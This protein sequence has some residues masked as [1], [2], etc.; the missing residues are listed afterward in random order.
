M[1]PSSLIFLTLLGCCGVCRAE[2]IRLSNDWKVKGLPATAFQISGK[3]VEM[4]PESCGAAQAVQIIKGPF[5]SGELLRFSADVETTGVTDEKGNKALRPYDLNLSPRN[6]CL[7][8]A[9][10]D[11]QGRTLSVCGSARLLGS[12]N[13]RLELETSVQ[14]NVE[15]VELRLMA[16]LVTGKVRC[17]NMA[18]EK[19]PA[20]PLQN[21][22]E[23][24]ILTNR[25]GRCFWQIDGKT[26][27]LVMYFGNNQF[28][29]D[30]R[31]LEEMEKA[32]GAGVP[33]LSFNLYLPAMASDTE[34]LKIIERF[35]KP[36]PDA[37]F[38]PRVWL[39]PGEAYQNSFPEEMMKYAGGRIGGY[40]S[41]S[42]EHWKKFTDHNLRELVKL[43]RRSPYAKQFAG[44]KLTYHQTGEWIYW[45]PQSSAGYD[46]PTRRDFARWLENKYG[47]KYENITVPTEE[48]RNTGT[49]GEF[50]DPKT[51]QREIDFSLFYNTANAD[52][53][54]RFARTVKEA[55]ENKSLV[56]AF[57]GYLFELAWNENWPQQAGHLG[58][59]KLCRSPYIDIIGAPYSYNPIGRGFGLPVDLHGP[60]DG[61]NRYGKVA[62]IEEDT[63]TH[64]ALNPKAG[65]GWDPA[66]APGYA[67]RTADMT[68][69]VAV[70]RRDLGV[71]AA[72]NQMLLWQNLF[73]EGRFNDRQIWDMYKPY[74]AWM[75]QSAETAPPFQPQV[76]VLADPENITLLKNK[77]YG[78]T[79]RWLYQNR[80]PL[81]RVDASIGYYLQSDLDKLPGSVRCI[82]MLN[83]FRITAEQKTVLKER[84]MRDGKM[85]IFC[86]MPD[87]YDD[88]GVTPDGTGFC[89]INLELKPGPIIPESRANG[90][91]SPDSRGAHFG[92]KQFG[93]QKEQPCAPFLKVTDSDAVVFANYTATGEAS[94]AL[95][96][97]NGWTSVYLGSP[98][99]PP[100]LWRELFRKAD[101]HLYLDDKTFSQ[102]F[103]KPDFIQAD[104]KFL[105]IQS[106]CGGTK[107]IHLP[108]RAAKV[109]R[110]DD[111][112]PQLIAE[113]CDEFRADLKPGIPAFFLCE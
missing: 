63:F 86:Y 113:D 9:Q 109:Y 90:K 104:G 27:P 75:Q 25:L 96:E 10:I 72:R 14:E 35:M 15:T 57:Y 21:I 62:M 78:I 36:F 76:A 8:L 91:I 4:R 38:M 66:I 41:A 28:N 59:E 88:S 6:V 100:G 102:D 17:R 53:I 73:S 82:V 98:G 50:R 49:L 68:Q 112:A 11:A 106:A 69:T 24:K 81:N 30:D 12:E 89:G 111:S 22:P 70:L 108:A 37:Y 105:M 1:N 44:L 56:A 33:V 61:I 65:D 67:S 23:A 80:F 71:A 45:E 5:K 74:L 18:F 29:R 54:I 3:T 58:L 77:A 42:S 93:M 92:G 7:A 32:V 99:L 84:F 31:I 101:C 95:K 48:E 52:N 39:G 110:F 103:E 16:T 64:L 40:A 60:F 85:I 83:P 19:M 107:T 47:K 2:E 34:L 26:R 43:I 51:R 13:T 87:I 79:E 46:E 20:P 97:M 94:C 55:T